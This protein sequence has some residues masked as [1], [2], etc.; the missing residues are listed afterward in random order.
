[1]E[2]TEEA[3]PEFHPARKGDIVVMVDLFDTYFY[4]AHSCQRH[5]QYLS[6]ICDMQLPTNEKRK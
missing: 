3:K 4:A 6:Q 1:M 2:M 5:T